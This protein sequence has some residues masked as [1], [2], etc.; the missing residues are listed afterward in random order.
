MKRTYLSSALFFFSIAISLTFSIRTMR[1]FAAPQPAPTPPAS[2]TPE[3]APAADA[4]ATPDLALEPSA[5]PDDELASAD[6]TAIIAFAI[7]MVVI[8]FFGVQWGG[9]STPRAAREK[10]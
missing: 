1:A 10:K 9:R 2:V 8:V 7:A 4:S 5:T 6:T 3:L